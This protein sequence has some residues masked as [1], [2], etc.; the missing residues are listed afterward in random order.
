L[1]FVNS[2]GRA[3]SELGGA[4]LDDDSDAVV[5][6]VASGVDEAGASPVVVASDDEEVP[7]AATAPARA[8]EASTATSRRLL[9]LRVDELRDVPRHVKKDCDIR[10]PFRSVAFSC[11]GRGVRYRAFVRFDAGV[12]V[13]L[14]DSM[15]QIATAVH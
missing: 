5:S 10:F 3:S 6:W 15:L 7:H 11:A 2:A 12:F 9:N 13:L 8:I 14:S 1:T 4:S